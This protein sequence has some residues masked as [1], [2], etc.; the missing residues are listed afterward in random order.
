MPP[1]SSVVRHLLLLL[2]L[3]DFTSINTSS[4]GS[5]KGYCTSDVELN[6]LFTQVKNINVQPFWIGFLHLRGVLSKNIP[7]DKFSRYFGC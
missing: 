5:L 7:L 4:N 2:V 6:R 3:I 1:E